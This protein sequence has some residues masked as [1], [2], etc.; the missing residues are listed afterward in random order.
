MRCLLTTLVLAFTLSAQVSVLSKEEA[1][2]GWIALFDGESL[3]GWTSE[4]GSQWKVVNGTLTSESGEYGWLRH[5]AMFAD[6][7][8]HCEFRTTADGNS[9]IFLRSAAVG[10]PHLS[11]Y[12]L[13]IFDKHPK[14]PTGSL[15]GHAASTGAPILANEW[16]S[17]DV[18]VDRTHMVVKLDGKLVAEATDGKALV[19]HIGLQYVK[20][21]KVEFRNIRLRPLGLKPLNDGKS[22]AGWKKVE[23]SKPAASPADWSAKENIIHVEKGPGQLESEKTFTHFVLQLDIRTNP[24]EASHHP[25]SGV[26]LRGVPG[27]WWSGYEV[28]IRNEYSDDDRGKPVD[29]GTG[30]IYRSQATRRIVAEDG[31]FFSETV[32]A[33]GRDFNVWVNGFPVTSWHDDRPEG[34][35]VRD[36]QAMLKP[37]TIS[38]QAHDPTTNLDFRNLR[39]AELPGARRY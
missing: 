39:I 5:N 37:G 30:A 22:L 19:G 14:F 21:K 3:F 7:Q 24:A 12:E 1:A 9:G 10:A 34:A 36:N 13:Q 11:G 35:S 38:L 15:V 16:H 20:D 29:F 31:E 2:N 27:V 18:T 23:P 28:Q 25:N 33:S 4:G 26:F 32:V 17:F 6:F 8:L